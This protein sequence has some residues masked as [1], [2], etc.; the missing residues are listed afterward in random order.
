M[1]H[2]LSKADSEQTVVYKPRKADRQTDRDRDKKN[3]TIFLTP[4]KLIRQ[5]ILSFS[6]FHE[7]NL[8]KKAHPRALSFVSS[9]MLMLGERFAV[10]IWI[11]YGY[12]ERYNYYTTLT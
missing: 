1:A 6:A 5:K 9:L 11:R 10:L 12:E 2:L 8:T 3:S 7:C 4:T